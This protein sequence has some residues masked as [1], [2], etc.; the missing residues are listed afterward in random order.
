V[1]VEYKEDG[2]TP[3]RLLMNHETAFNNDNFRMMPPLVDML[4]D[5]LKQHDRDVRALSAA[6][7]SDEEEEALIE[8][9][10][11]SISV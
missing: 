8:A 10:E 4:R 3:S 11:L 6:V 1:I 7:L 9:G 2:R 5:I